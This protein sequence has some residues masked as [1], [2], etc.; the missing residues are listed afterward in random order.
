MSY[1]RH[2]WKFDVLCEHAYLNPS[3]CSIDEFQN[4]RTDLSLLSRLAVRH[5]WQS[6]RLQLIPL[7]NSHML[8]EVFISSTTGSPWMWFRSVS[9]CKAWQEELLVVKKKAQSHMIKTL[10]IVKCNQY[11]LQPGWREVLEGRSKVFQ[12]CLTKPKGVE[13]TMN[14]GTRSSTP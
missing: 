13:E 1:A 4:T 8:V 2:T 7:V 14:K 9:V 6:S 11:N 10:E 5:F 12:V 3:M